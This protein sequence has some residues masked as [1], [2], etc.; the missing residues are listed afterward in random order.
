MFLIISEF[1]QHFSYLFSNTLHEFTLDSFTGRKMLGIE[2]I[3]WLRSVKE[4]YS[5]GSVMHLSS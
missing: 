4:F 2:N 3:L 5:V 1:L